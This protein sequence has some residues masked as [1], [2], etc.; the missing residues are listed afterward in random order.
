MLQFYFDMDGVLAIF[1]DCR[2]LPL[3]RKPFMKEGSHYFLHRMPDYKALEIF[4]TLY[5][6][7]VPGAS[8]KILTRLLDEDDH[9]TPELRREW[10]TDKRAWVLANTTGVDTSKCFIASG[11]D[12][13]RILDHVPLRLRKYHV[14]VD[15]YNPNLRNWQSAGGT[16]V[17]YINDLNTPES[18]DGPCLM[19][20]WSADKCVDVL[21]SLGAGA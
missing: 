4:Q 20:S 9:I 16:A 7:A 5:G 11:P 17:K 14:L 13:G 10:W 21:L 6:P 1:Q 8:A 12:K 19:K 2:H 18:F 15:D 3:E